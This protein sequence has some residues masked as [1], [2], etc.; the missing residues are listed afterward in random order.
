ML[1]AF[2]KG[3]TPDQIIRFLED[4][5]HPCTIKVGKEIPRNVDDQI[6]LWYREQELV[7][8]EEVDVYIDFDGVKNIMHG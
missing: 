1:K 2:R 5:A 7:V 6:H 3:I 8:A 4:H